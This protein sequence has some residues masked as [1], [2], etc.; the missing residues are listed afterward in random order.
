MFPL[1][2]LFPKLCQSSTPVQIKIYTGHYQAQV[3]VHPTSQP[4]PPDASGDSRTEVDQPV[5][6]LCQHHFSPPGMSLSISS[7]SSSSSSLSPGMS[8][9]ADP[10]WSTLLHNSCQGSIYSPHDEPRIYCQ[11][12]GSAS[13]GQ[14]LVRSWPWAWWYNTL[15]WLAVLRT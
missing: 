11:A 5:R 8:R 15:W 4:T 2:W 9:T 12:H 13:S 7:S 14:F 10:K 1:T 3:W 6:T